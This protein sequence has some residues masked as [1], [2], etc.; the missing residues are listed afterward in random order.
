MQ[1]IR[2][3]HPMYLSLFRFVQIWI[4][5][6]RC[7]YGLDYIY[8]FTCSYM[9]ILNINPCANIIPPLKKHVSIKSR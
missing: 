4:D 7:H 6:V 2:M 3:I 9:A 8:I 1:P 5:L